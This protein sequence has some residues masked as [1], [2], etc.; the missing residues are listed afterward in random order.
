MTIASY[1]QSCLSCFRRCP[2]EY[3]LR[4]QQQLERLGDARETL[5]VGDCWHKAHDAASKAGADGPAYAVIQARAPGELWVEKLRRLF[6]AYRWRWASHALKMH[7]SEQRFEYVDA[8]GRTRRGQIDGLIEI[9]GQ[10]GNLERKTSG[11]DI[12]DGSTYWQ[13]QRMGTQ[14]SFYA[15]AF[16]TLTGHPPAFTLYDVVRKPTIRPKSIVKADMTRL[17][18]ELMKSG[19]AVYFGEKF[20]PEEIEAALAAG[21]ETSAL[22]GARL[23]ADIGDRPDFYFARK[24]IARTT[25]DLDLAERDTVQTIDAIESLSAQQEFDREH[26]DA[27]RP[28]FPRN[29]DACDVFGVCDFFALCSNGEYPQPNTAPNGFARRA[30]LHPE[31]DEVQ[32]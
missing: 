29:P 31:L 32:Q 6:A 30:A 24:M 3:D 21:M 12:D 4:Y 9:E 5:A 8:E 15:N 25:L 17:R 2:R 1:T 7:A 20:G 27:P 11:E 10:I 18:A 28:M 19:E 16:K 23:T 22:Y 13:R 14:V 26:F